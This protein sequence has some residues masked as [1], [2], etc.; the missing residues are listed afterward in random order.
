LPLASKCSTSLVMARPGLDRV[1]DVGLAAS[2][3]TGELTS[4]GMTLSGAVGL[5][6]AGAVLT[7][8]TLTHLVS[9]LTNVGEQAAGGRCSRPPTM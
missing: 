1:V 2:I 7:M 9:M 6:R 3:A 5:V 4:N 8:S